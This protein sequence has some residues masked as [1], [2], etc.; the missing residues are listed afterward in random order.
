MLAATSKAIIPM[1]TTKTMAKGRGQTARKA[2]ATVIAANHGRAIPSRC[3]IREG[4][5]KKK[6]LT[7][8]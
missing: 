7:P 8:I 3:G 6:G 2:A 4:S 1:K 5:K